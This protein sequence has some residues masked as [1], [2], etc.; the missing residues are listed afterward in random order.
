MTNLIRWFAGVCLS[1]TVAVPMALAG[2]V[3]SADVKKTID[4]FKFKDPSIKARFESAH[5]YAVFPS[6]GKGGLV[7]GGARG[8]GKVYERG[9][10]IGTVEM[11]QVTIG[12]QAGGQAFSELIFFENKAA[13]DRFTASNYEFAANASAIVAKSGS[14][15]SS[16]YRNG[17]I[18]FTNAKEGVMLEAAI[19]SQKFTFHRK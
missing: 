1:F 7:V 18:V 12:L 6:I 14:S 17:V 10:E 16:N 8:D 4:T 15:S 11:S 3:S 19:G 5:A 13:L 2:E 9:R